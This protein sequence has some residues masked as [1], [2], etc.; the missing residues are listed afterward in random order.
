MSLQSKF[1]PSA[2]EFIP[3]SEPPKR[4]DSSKKDPNDP[5]YRFN[6]ASSFQSLTSHLNEVMDTGIPDKSVAILWIENCIRARE[7]VTANLKERGKPT[8]KGH[9]KVIK[10]LKNLSK[11]ITLNVRSDEG[12]AFG[13]KENPQR[14]LI[15]TYGNK[16][17]TIY[18]NGILF[19]KLAYDGGRK[20]TR[21]NR[22]SKRKTY[23]ILPRVE[24]S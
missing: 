14:F 16:K 3:G 13:F 21:K 23:R 10:M 5:H 4:D 24:G 12:A 18:S 9:E 20:S 7:I 2:P 1:N 11:Y 15:Q 17:A 8:D 19:G 6:C 22:K